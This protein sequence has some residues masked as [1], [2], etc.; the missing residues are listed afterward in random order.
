MNLQQLC[1][2]CMTNK[3]EASQCP[4]CGFVEG[5]LPESPQHLV[6]RTM[7][8]DRY[9]LGRVLGQGG[10]G[11]TYLAWDI[12]L[13]TKLAVKEYLP[14]D[15]ATRSAQ[16]TE[17]SV[18]SGDNRQHFLSGLEKFLEEAKILAQFN[19]SQGIVS[20][21]DFFRENGTAYLVMYYLDGI[22]F[23]QYLEQ[24]G[25]KIPF[26]TAKSIM[27]PVLEALADVHANGLLHRDISPDNIYITT[28]RQVKLLDFGAARH[29]ITEHSKSLSVILKPGFA[30]EEQYRTKGKQGPWTDV[31]AAAATLYRSIVGTVP[32]ESL[33]R[34][35]E[36]T[37]ELPSS[38][39]VA[40]PPHAETA[41]LKALSVRAP[42]RYQSM[43]EFQQALSGG[44]AMSPDQQPTQ[45]YRDPNATVHVPQQAQSA[46][47]YGHE[48]SGSPAYP[49][50]GAGAASSASPQQDARQPFFA[51][52]YG[53]QQPQSTQPYQ[54]APSQPYQ[55]APSQNYQQAPSQ[56]YQQ[57]P[58]HAQSNAPYVSYNPQ[59]RPQQSRKG[60][61][62]GLISAL[63]VVGL[64]IGAFFYISGGGEDKK[65]GNYKGMAIADVRK[66][67]RS[68][69]I[70]YEVEEDYNDKYDKGEV[71][72]QSPSSGTTMESGDVVE[73]TVSLGEEKEEPSPAPS[74]DLV[75]PSPSVEPTPSAEPDTG[76][77][78]TADQQYFA[79]T[80][81]V[82]E[83][84]P[85]STYQVADLNSDGTVELGLGYPL[86]NGSAQVTAFK[87]NGNGFTAW[88]I[89]D[90]PESVIGLARS[91]G[92]GTDTLVAI[93]VNKIYEMG[94]DQGTTPVNNFIE[95]DEQ[96]LEVT[97]G[98]LDSDSVGD[99]AALTTRD[100]TYY[101]TYNVSSNPSSEALTL[102]KYPNN[103]QLADLNGD[104][105]SE[106]LYW[107]EDGTI[108]ANEWNGSNF[109]ETALFSFGEGILSSNFHTADIDGNGT[110]EVVTVSEVNGVLQGRVWKWDDA[111]KNLVCRQIFDLSGFSAA[112]AP[113][114]GDFDYDGH[115]DILVL[116]V[117]SNDAGNTY[118]TLFKDGAL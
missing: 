79:Q 32:P 1:M 93:A 67:L 74:D 57:A 43:G 71:I 22:T 86:D 88:G 31:Y 91:P 73:L 77:E 83:T 63:V 55:Q 72:K 62:I 4:T 103:M 108:H 116:D 114:F 85:L 92:N 58:M 6:P 13:D 17:V 95:T 30:P 44:G 36:D 106:L 34:M 98:R 41:L 61:W 94:M 47:G 9:L 37:L 12:N 35:E 45:P 70:K 104:G 102:E 23:K 20:V 100:G 66:E 46:G 2:G 26:E 105:I 54:Q 49:V 40:I 28:G 53:G 113:L 109:E 48:A 24:M 11:I 87:W 19:N 82:F 18:Y 97:Y 64:G 15:F 16:Q 90:V 27:N 84:Y 33:D 115:N 75:E 80:S 38:L 59:P 8:N 96:L 5:T 3:G 118:F 7:L 76:G 25:G 101:I 51:Q 50:S 112:V 117:D 81:G 52:S 42:L 29:S 68:K 110:Y 39:G 60:L 107:G 56:P 111:Q 89:Y 10:F 99:V 69:G 78:L 21:R 14:R 65:I